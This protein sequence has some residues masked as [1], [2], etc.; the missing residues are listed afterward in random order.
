MRRALLL[1]PLIGCSAPAEAAPPVE[2]VTL[3]SVGLENSSLDRSVDPCVDFYQYACGGWLKTSPIPSDRARWGRDQEIEERTKVNIRQLLEDAA[4]GTSGDASSKKLGDFYAACMD[5]AA[6]EKAG[7]RPVD[8]LLTKTLKVKDQKSWLAAVEELHKAG[9]WVVW[10]E[11]A[12][13]D[14]KDSS[15]YV[16]Y[17]DSAGLGLPDRDYY[18]KPELADKLAGYKVHVGRMLGLGAPSLVPKGNPEVAASDV[19]AI[20]T[21]LAKVTK[22]VE[23]N[24]DVDKSYN[25]TDAKGLK[26][27]IDWKGYWKAVGHEP[28]KKIIIGT[29]AYFTA[30]DK[31]RTK[32][33]PA[34]WSAYFTYHALAANAFNLPKPYDDQMFELD[35]LVRG[36][37]SRPERAKRCIDATR[38]GLG[39][40][41]GQAYVARFF[42][43]SAKQSAITLIDAIVKAMGAEIA[44]VDWMSDATKQ[45][46]QGKLAKIAR[47]VGYPDKWRTYDFDVKRDDFAG[48]RQRAAAFDTHRLVARAGKPVDR[49]EWDMQTYDINAYYDPTMNLTALPAGILQAPY[50]G[51]DRSVAANFGGIGAV[52]GH[53]LTHGFDDQ[54]AKFDADGNLKEWW[55]KDDVKHFTERGTCVSDQYSTFEAAK[56]Q[57]INGKQTLGEDIADI[58]GTRMAFNA[59]RALRAGASKQYVADGFTEDQQFFLA[60]AQSWCTKDRPAE[61]QRRLTTDVHSPPKFRVYGP[62]RNLREF[63]DAFKCAAGT[64]MNPAKSCTVW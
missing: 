19:V 25:P 62:L 31:L 54:G 40:L 64:P 29:P 26:L 37:E 38:E 52:V 1:L 35:K 24:R 23:E 46:A 27:K 43:S 14:F 30:L 59:Y 63:S 16:T 50:F 60:Y 39:E 47:M 13:T 55:S 4:K 17:L 8:A 51:A 12:Y 3:A 32:F 48:N 5:E 61:L 42:P 18:V 33:K 58:G 9:V 7:T 56:G 6:I 2:K 36:V 20:E 22:T 34:Q 44:K 45:V 28:S 15:K 57:F 41:L 11:V 53:E 10:N 21:E 49:T